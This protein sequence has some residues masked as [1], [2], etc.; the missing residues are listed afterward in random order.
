[1][2]VRQLLQGKE[3]ALLKDENNWQVPLSGVLLL[4]QD[5]GRYDEQK[6][7]QKGLSYDLFLRMVLTFYPEAHLAMRGLD[8]IEGE[9][10]Q[11]EGCE[12]I[13]V[14]HCIEKLTAQFWMEDMELERSYQYE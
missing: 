13:H 5:A 14:D 12:K 11:T 7:E 4:L 8:V 9:L 1:M 2:E 10:R 6:T 3:V